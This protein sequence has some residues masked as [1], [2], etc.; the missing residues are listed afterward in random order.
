MLQRHNLY[1]IR[2][3]L[4]EIGEN[5]DMYGYDREESG[6]Y[7]EYKEQFD[8]LATGAQSLLEALDE[9][10]VS[11]NWDDMTVRLRCSMNDIAASA[12]AQKTTLVRAG[13]AGWGMTYAAPARRLSWMIWRTT[14]T[15]IKEAWIME[16]A[17]DRI[18]DEMAVAA[19][20]R[21]VQYVGEQL[22][23]HI[24]T[25][26]GDAPKFY[27]EGKTIA[28]AMKKLE[29]YARQHKNGSM[30]CVDPETGMRIILEYYGVKAGGAQTPSP[31]PAASIADELDL[32][33]LLEM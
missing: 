25:H 2:E 1:D 28:G 29:D 23:R 5:G 7:Q 22:T 30:A 14:R 9:W 3:A 24:M 21:N 26:R 20:D 4:W 15:L 18:R 19:K 11:E 16:R 27:A 13:A 12:A 32:D 17:I 6:Y 33:A 10:D 31:K 8:E